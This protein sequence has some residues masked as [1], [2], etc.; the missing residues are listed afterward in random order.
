MATADI[1]SVP[2]RPTITLSRRLTTLDTVFWMMIGTTMET[3]S[4]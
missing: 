3:T 1:W 4:A 2:T